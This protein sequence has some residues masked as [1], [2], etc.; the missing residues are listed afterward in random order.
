MAVTVLCVWLAD[1]VNPIRRLERQLGDLDEQVRRRAAVRLGYL[2]HDARSASKSLVRATED[3]SAPVRVA[4]VWALSRVSGRAD[5]LT[6]LLSD[7]DKN[8]AMAAAE[9]LLWNGEDPATVVP[10]LLEPH[11]NIAIFS[12]MSPAQAAIV[13][14][15][16]LDSLSAT[17]GPAEQQSADPAQVALNFVTV[18]ATTVVPD[19]IER[20]DDERP[21]VRIAAAAQL[22]RLREK[23]NQAAPALRARLQDPDAEVVLACAAALGAVEPSDTE[24]L[25]ILKRALRSKDVRAM[26]AAYFLSAMGPAANGLAD[27]LVEFLVSFQRYNIWGLPGE[28]ALVR[29]GPPAVSAL[30]GALKRAVIERSQL[31]RTV[32]VVLERVKGIAGVALPEVRSACERVRGVT[33]A[34]GVLLDPQRDSHRIAMIRFLEWMEHSLAAL[35]ERDRRLVIPRYLALIGPPAKTAVPTLV[36]ALDYADF[37]Y[38]AIHALASIGQDAAPAADRLWLFVDSPDKHLRNAALRALQQMGISDKSLRARLRPALNSRDPDERVE[39]ALLISEFGA[40]ADEILAV[41]HESA[42]D[43]QSYL[44]EALEDGNSNVRRAAAEVAGRVG[45]AAKD[46]VVS[47]TSNDPELCYL[48]AAL[49]DNKPAV[50]REAAEALG[51]IGPTAT[52][53]VPR[54]IELLDD[55]DSW[56]AA[57]EALGHIGPAARAAVPKLLKSLQAMQQLPDSG[58][59]DYFPEEY[60]AR[61]DALAGIGSGALD[62]VPELLRL[63]KFDD[64]AICGGAVVTLA[65]IDPTHPS[66]V[67]RLRILLVELERRST[68]GSAASMFG[69]G[70]NRFDNL[71]DKIADTVWE[72]GPHA[73]P[74][75]PDLE[76]I[77]TANHLVDLKVRCYAA[78][79]LARFQPHRQTAMAY[80]KSAPR[81]GHPGSPNLA[82]KLLQRIDGVRK[83]R[84]AK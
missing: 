47:M 31:P 25:P 56:D 30:D 5:V 40:S 32:Q 57:A 46:A 37:Q 58:E 53:A 6:S 83:S 1:Y 36:A 82:D 70:G 10:L 80:L 78:F 84:A 65:R 54:L 75:V 61:L 35:A 33:D 67:P 60:F 71:A 2:G 27:D 12:A 15:L 7:S 3:T 50:R 45:P 48:T 9:G 62:A 17:D 20:L 8:V 23:A 76:R 52:D 51:R 63:A 14:P 72:L 11:V 79:A 73:E 74:L 22:S 39:E 4:A 55:E 13:V 21:N 69:M 26:Q 68:I 64:R 18:P 19:L 16:F 49:Q 34:P 41:L 44:T 77:V 42:T 59:Y 43:V 81:L 29:M 24:F 28:A 66:L 38:P